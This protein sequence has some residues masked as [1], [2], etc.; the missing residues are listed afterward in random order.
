[1]KCANCGTEFE[2]K[3]CP[4]CGLKATP[5]PETPPRIRRGISNTAPQASDD[6]G[7][8]PLHK[9]WWLW[10]IIAIAAIAIL[11]SIIDSDRSNTAEKVVPQLVEF[12]VA[13]VSENSC[14]FSYEEKWKIQY[15]KNGDGNGQVRIREDAVLTCLGEYF[16]D[17]NLGYG[18][19]FIYNFSEDDARIVLDYEL[20]DG[21]LS[22]LSY[23]FDKDEYVTLVG[24]KRYSLADE[25][26]EYAKDFGLPELLKS[27]VETFHADLES[28]GLSASEVEF[29]DY[30]SVKDALSAGSASN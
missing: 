12:T 17:Y 6:R 28:F 13:E 18:G 7:K 5:E 26:V 21:R 22:V 15:L 24:G 27:D 1:M 20:P 8:K 4:K 30:E 11:F 2:G 16:D 9:K 3:F 14:D 10:V 19:D 29:L 25:F 23:D